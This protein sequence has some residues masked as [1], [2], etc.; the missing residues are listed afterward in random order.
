MTT[1][2]IATGFSRSE[3]RERVV[4]FVEDDVLE[5]GAVAHYLRD[6]GFKVIESATARE[7]VEVLNSQIPIDVVFSDVWLP[8]GMNGLGLASWIMERYPEMPVLLT[9]GYL[10]FRVLDDGFIA[11]PFIYRDLEIRLRQLLGDPTLN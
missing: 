10:G 4:L 6:V 7:A 3:S 11:K 9:S 5:R 2:F 8:G 1:S